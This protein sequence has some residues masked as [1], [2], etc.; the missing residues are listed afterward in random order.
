MTKFHS[1][2]QCYVDT[3]KIRVAFQ[4]LKLVNSGLLATKGKWSP[5]YS[6]GFS[7]RFLIL[8]NSNM[9]HRGSYVMSL[10]SIFDLAVSIE[11]NFMYHG[12]CLIRQL[13]V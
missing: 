2:E 9:H 7:C 3:Q 1:Y 11:I 4:T 13:R 12:F 10:F 8:Y 6:I 5:K